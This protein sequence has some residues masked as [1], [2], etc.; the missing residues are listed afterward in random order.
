MLS[1]VSDAALRS[2][3]GVIVGTCLRR[4]ARTDQPLDAHAVEMFMD[5]ARAKT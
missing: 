1:A 4:S 3:D 5:V 2:A